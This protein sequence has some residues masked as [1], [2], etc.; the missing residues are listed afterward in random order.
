MKPSL[1]ILVACASLCAFPAMAMSPDEMRGRTADIAARYLEIWS[2]NDGA[3]VAGVPYMYGPTVQFYGRTYTQRQLADEKRR[4][5]AQWPVRRYAHRP[6]TLRVVCNAAEMKCGA[7]STIDFTV[8]NPARGTRKSGS[9][10]FDL[11]V[12]FA[13]RQPRILYEGGSIGRGRAD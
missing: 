7:R 2:S 10:R 9:A 13:E 8:A 3:A 5:I 6:G 12:G 1:P 4:T 11:G